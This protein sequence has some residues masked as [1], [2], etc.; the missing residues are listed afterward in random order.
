MDAL[1]CL[2]T[3][4]ASVC[5]GM[6]YGIM[7]GVGVSIGALLLRSL[8]PELRSS[9]KTEPVTGQAYILMQPSHGL[10]FPS[11][12]HIT[13]SIL[14]QT[15]KHKEIQLVLLDFSKWAN[16]DYTAASTLVSVH[17]G[18]KKNGKTLAFLNC[19]EVWMEVLKIAGLGNP[20]IVRN[21]D[22]DLARYIKETFFGE[23]VKND[24]LGDVVSSGEKGDQSL[25]PGGGGGGMMEGVGG[26]SMASTTGSSADVTSL[27]SSTKPLV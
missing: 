9:L 20:P 3:F 2:V 16:C 24:I 19:S 11:V 7:V 18:M 13:T 21:E 17:K 5:L 10:N 15:L 25:S 22:H 8:R 12:D 26:I 1:A 4:I 23:S 6:E 27:A 14:K